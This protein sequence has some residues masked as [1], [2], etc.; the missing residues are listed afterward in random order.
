MKTTRADFYNTDQGCSIKMVSLMALLS[1]PQPMRFTYCLGPPPIRSA[2][3]STPPPWHSHNSF[4]SGEPSSK[5]RNISFFF[6]LQKIPF[7]Q[8]IPTEL[9]F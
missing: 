2:Y 8:R 9:H 6:S 5:N 3:Q 1:Y 7:E 4:F